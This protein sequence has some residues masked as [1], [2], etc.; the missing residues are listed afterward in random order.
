MFA[1]K[2][3]DGIDDVVYVAINSYWEDLTIELPR[4]PEGHLWRVS[5][6]S[7]NSPMKEGSSVGSTFLCKAR[8][9]VALVCSQR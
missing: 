5:L 3:K 6:D 2:T 9:V 8:S 7:S 1:G 4:L